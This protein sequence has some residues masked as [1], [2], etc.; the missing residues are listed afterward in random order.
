MDM[1]STIS[2]QSVPDAPSG[3]SRSVVSHASVSLSWDD[4]QDGSITGY[5]VLRRD[6]S[7]HVA[8]VFDVIADDTGSNAT[9]YVDDTVAPARRYVYRVKARSTDGLSAWSNYVNVTTP[10]AP[11]NGDNQGTNASDPPAAPTGL[12]QTA[13]AHDGVTLS[14]DDPQDASI[15][16]YQVLRRNLAVHAAGFFEVIAADT[17]SAATAYVDTS[18]EPSSDYVYRVQARSANGLSA[19][20]N[21]VKLSTPAAPAV[22]ETVTVVQEPVDPEGP[23][24]AAQQVQCGSGPEEL[25][26]T[27]TVAASGNHVGYNSG[28]FG[29]LSSNTLSNGINV[30]WIHYNTSSMVLTL[31]FS[32]S[33]H[34]LSD[35]HSL[36]I[37]SEV[38]AIRHAG[39]L[40]GGDPNDGFTWRLSARPAWA[41]DASEHCVLL[42]RGT[43]TCIE[44]EAA[45]YAAHPRDRNVLKIIEPN[46][47][48]CFMLNMT[49][50]RAS[51]YV[52]F[53][54][55][56]GNS[57][58]VRLYYS[59]PDGD[60]REDEPFNS[61]RH[62][63]MRSA[64]A[65]DG[66]SVPTGWHHWQIPGGAAGCATAESSFVGQQRCIDNDGWYWKHGTID[67]AT[68]HVHRDGV[69]F[70]A[71]GH[72]H[73]LIHPDFNYQ[74]RG[75]RV[76]VR[77]DTLD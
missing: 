56:Q 23:L 11:N 70:V 61:W 4:P 72:Q 66:R 30:Y 45:D 51:N 40:P 52:G 6:L 17:G 74:E 44:L 3:L 7:V 27:M 59:T 8:G 65:S 31:R 18:V 46:G 22:I 10:T 57:Y 48:L 38:Y 36:V 43:T 14:W 54:V 16:G 34:R 26:A 1:P 62:P 33:K 19:R 15:T 29:T 55:E 2:A 47:G 21:F 63:W 12:T 9:T 60:L 28:L 13:L 58:R 53:P 71:I 35:S 50:R 77:V 64:I 41:V 39:P 24:V 73:G 76:V 37:G 25:A 68:Q 42:S 75:W 69:L 20:S 49:S 67:F 32:S 5:Q